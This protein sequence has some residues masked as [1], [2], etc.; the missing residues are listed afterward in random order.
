M[1]TFWNFWRL[2]F[3]KSPKHKIQ[4]PWN[5]IERHFWTSRISKID[6]MYVKSNWQQNA[7]IS[8]LCYTDFYVVLIFCSLCK[9]TMCLLVQLFVFEQ[10]IPSHSFMNGISM[11]VMT[12]NSVFVKKLSNT[13]LNLLWL[14]VVFTNVAKSLNLLT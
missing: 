14:K 6:F 2:K 9:S 8:T 10:K 13:S 12:K 1:I 3:A 5:F 7:D 4:S 11:N